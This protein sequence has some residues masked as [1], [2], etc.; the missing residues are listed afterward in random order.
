MK[1]T[2]FT[3]TQ[4]QAQMGFQVCLLRRYGD[5]LGSIVKE[6]WLQFVP[7]AWMEFTK[8]SAA[9]TSQ[10]ASMYFMHDVL[11]FGWLEDSPVQLAVLHSKWNPFECCISSIEI[12]NWTFYSK[13]LL[14][15]F[16]G[17]S[18]I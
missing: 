15:T 5:S 6:T 11:I 12:R 1:I 17:M 10:Y 2:G 16:L 7:C 8:E 3:T 13:S 4:L 9:G 18:I 14:P